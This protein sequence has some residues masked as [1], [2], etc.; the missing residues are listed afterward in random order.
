VQVL[1]SNNGT[2]GVA[3][4]HHSTTATAWSSNNGP[5]FLES[6]ALRDEDILGTIVIF[7]MPKAATNGRT[8]KLAKSFRCSNVR[9]GGWSSFTMRNALWPTTLIP[10]ATIRNDA[11]SQFLC[12]TFRR[13]L[14]AYMLF[15]DE[16]DGFRITWATVVDSLDQNEGASFDVESSN[17]FFHPNTIRPSRYDIVVRS[18]SEDNTWE[19]CLSNP[20]TGYSHT[21]C[22]ICHAD[23]YCSE[24]LNI[25]YE[26]YLHIDALLSDIIS[27]RRSS[28]FLKSPYQKECVF[29]MPEFF[30]NLIGVLPES[31]KVVLV[32]V[33]SNKEMMMHSN[34]KV[35]SALGVILE[36][37]LFDQS[38]DELKWV[39]HPSCNES[40]S[41]KEWCN[42]LALNWRMR[43]CN[44]GI[45]CLESCK[46]ENWVCG[47]HEC[48]VDEDLNDDFNVD[49]W[50]DYVE[51]RN[52][53][54][55]KSLVVAPKDVSMSSLY[56]YCDVVTN[57]AV[58]NAVPVKRMASRNSPIELIYG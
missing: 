49:F 34:K 14:S 33:F 13:A 50:S 24:G 44:V 4:L 56:P 52:S 2:V 6:P 31:L 42:S 18:S 39:Q 3:F 47:T 53:S 5:T 40:S 27:R 8:P 19:E 21:D 54:K 23:Q 11:N 7:E 22:N 20:E 58:H 25:G 45:F 36:V 51:R 29:F 9:V 17:P 43:E 26:A 46:L 48:N 41:M 12:T 57:Q 32:I 1:L 15:N 37:N 28:L 38:Y 16:D 30:Y 35:P 55:K 10:T